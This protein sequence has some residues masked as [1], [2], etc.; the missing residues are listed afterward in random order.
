[1]GTDLTGLP[2]VDISRALRDV[3][4]GSLTE[5]EMV[6]R[7]SRAFNPSVTIAWT[8]PKGEHQCDVVIDLSNGAR[9]GA[10]CDLF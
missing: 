5:K 6:R 10:T 3:A 2:D 4:K 8:K 7:I 1:M 9:H